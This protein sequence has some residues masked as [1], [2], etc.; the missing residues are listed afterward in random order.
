[1]SISLLPL[2]SLSLAVIGRAQLTLPSPAWQPPPSSSGYANTS[3]PSPSSGTQEWAT[4]LGEL[5]W[6]YDAQRSGN[7]SANGAGTNRVPWRNDSALSD[8]PAGGYYDAGDYLKFTFPLSWT[9]NSICWGALN[10]GQGYEN[11]NQS[12][13]LDSMLR[14]GLDWLMDAHPDN[15]T[16]VVQVGDATID[17]NYWGGDQNI[18]GPRPSYQINATHPGTDAAAQA[19]SALASC[20]LLYYNSTPL[21]SP[22]SLSSSSSSLSSLTSPLHA[23]ANPT[24]A[25]QLYAHAEALYSFA[26]DTTP[27]QLYQVAVPQVAGSYASSA[28]EDELVG[29]GLWVSLARARTLFNTTFASSTGSQNLKTLKGQPL[30]WDSKG[31]MMGVL[32]AQMLTSPTV[33]SS[34]KHGR[35]LT[36]SFPFRSIVRMSASG[37]I[38]GLLWYTDDSGSASLNP[39]L[40]AAMLVAQFLPLVSDSGRAGAYNTFYTSQLLYALGQNPMGLSYIVGTNPNAPTN[41]HSAMASGGS[42]IGNIDGDPSVEMWVLYGAVVGGPQGSDGRGDGYWDVSR[43]DWAQSEVALDYNAPL[44][45]LTSLGLLASYSTSSSSDTSS[46]TNLT[47]PYYFAS[48]P[49]GS[50]ASHRPSGSPCDAAIRTGCPSS[51]GG[52]GRTGRIVLGVVI[53]V[54]GLGLVIGLVWMWIEGRKRGVGFGGWW[55]MRK[56]K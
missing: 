41:P 2:F 1:M 19:A 8:V 24:Y 37:A 4:L 7:L 31:M 52:L 20:S 9:L 26:R 30:N 51:S 40:N 53:S 12:A 15:T 49:P 46:T 54:V 43:S 33:N 45:T 55:E 18:P 16:L 27:R 22:T 11:A 29:A 28:W 34:G 14:W 42:D 44:L 3:N 38:G 35:I 56:R 32:A 21:L 48:L 50:Y 5:I 23:L 17:N 13:Y 25:A 47:S 6:F 36:F 10:Y 39:A